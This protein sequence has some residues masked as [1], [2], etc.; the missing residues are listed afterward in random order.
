MCHDVKGDRPAFDTRYLRCCYHTQSDRGRRGVTDIEPN[1]EALVAA[2]KKVFDSGER[3]TF[4]DIDHNRGRQHGDPSRSD[5][6][7]R[8]LGADDDFSCAGESGDDLAEDGAA[9]TA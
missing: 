8:M 1:A 3:R 7:R 4:D 5:E 6:R 9:G 2:R